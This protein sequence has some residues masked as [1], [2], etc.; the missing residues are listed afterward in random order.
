MS[1]TQESTISEK[2]RTAIQLSRTI[3]FLELQLENKEY[4]EQSRHE[5]T[6]AIAG[7][8][9]VVSDPAVNIVP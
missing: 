9:K 1:N 5:L 3:V 8:K 7:L 6:S 2:E 4:T